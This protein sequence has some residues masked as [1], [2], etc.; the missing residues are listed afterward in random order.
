MTKGGRSIER[1]KHGEGEGEMRVSRVR[2]VV[3]SAN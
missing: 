1:S 3:V 2:R